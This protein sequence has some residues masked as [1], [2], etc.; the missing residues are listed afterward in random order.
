MVVKEHRKVGSA[1]KFGLVAEA[2]ADLYP[3]LGPTSE[4]DTAAGEAL[5]VAAG[6]HV[7]K[8][9]GTP[10]VYG[11]PASAIPISSR[12]ARGKVPPINRRKT[13]PVY[14]I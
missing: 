14:A 12:A 5:L 1:A 10:L 8:L 4:W 6:G 3:R 2:T 11:K 13:W 9:D 7:E